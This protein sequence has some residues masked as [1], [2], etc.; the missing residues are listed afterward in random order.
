MSARS[1][2]DADHHAI[3][4]KIAM[5][6]FNGP[7]NPHTGEVD[8]AGVR[9]RKRGY[10]EIADEVTDEEVLAHW[11]MSSGGKTKP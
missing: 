4:A 10:F 2:T 6:R 7:N 3:K 1:M 11:T 9:L 5:A 8:P